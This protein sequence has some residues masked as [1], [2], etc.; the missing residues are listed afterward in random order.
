MRGEAGVWYTFDWNE[1]KWNELDLFIIHSFFV[2][3]SI[4]LST[5]LEMLWMNERTKNFNYGTLL[6]FCC[7]SYFRERKY[8]PQAEAMRQRDFT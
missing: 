4:W 7:F 1:M 6:S 3:I 8:T 5:I 2:S